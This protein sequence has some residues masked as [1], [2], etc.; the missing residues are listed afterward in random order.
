MTDTAIVAG[1]VLMPVLAIL[2]LVAIHR[3]NARQ[4]RAQ[5]PGRLPHQP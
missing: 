2:M 1:L 5:R 4:D 3:W